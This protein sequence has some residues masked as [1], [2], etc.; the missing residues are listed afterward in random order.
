MPI[1]PVSLARSPKEKVADAERYESGPGPEEMDD[2]HYGLTLHLTFAE[3]QK[4]G[5]ADGRLESGMKV[6]FTGMG[7]ITATE[8]ERVNGMSKR[9]ARLQVQQLGIEP[10]EDKKSP[11]S[12]I[13]G[14]TS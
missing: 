3:L 10:V 7:E 5:F 1:R 9:S 4:L 14:E 11:A 6:S 8:S 13:Y 2:Y 12:L